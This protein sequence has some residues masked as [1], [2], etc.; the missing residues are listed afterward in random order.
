MLKNTLHE[1][2]LFS[3]NNSSK[4]DQANAGQSPSG[5]NA[6]L[7]YVTM[8]KKW[9]NSAKNLRAFDSFVSVSS[10]LRIVCAKIR[11][12]KWNPGRDYSFST[13]G[14]FSKKW[15]FITTWFCVHTKWMIPYSTFYDWSVLRFN[16]DAGKALL[17]SR[18]TDL[19]FYRALQW[20][21]LHIQ[22][23]NNVE[24]ACKESTAKSIPLKLKPKKCTPWESEELCQKWKELDS[25]PSFKN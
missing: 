12:N 18:K 25:Q 22:H 20:A 6:Q 11:L 24:I 23:N 21:V 13:Y 4:K 10:D 2:N 17:L 8:N 9:K 15:R 1:N 3:L 7:N 14:K 19:V 5:N 16:P